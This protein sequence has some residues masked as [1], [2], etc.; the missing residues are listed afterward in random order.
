MERNIA[1]GALINEVSPKVGLGVIIVRN[2][3]VLLG[4]R[5]NS[6]DGSTWSFPGG[7]LGFGESFEQAAKRE[8]LEE[9][10]LEIDELELVSISNDIAYG[11]HYVTLGLMPLIIKGEVE[12]KEPDKF[13]CWEWFSFDKLPNPLFVATK[14]LIDNYLKERFYQKR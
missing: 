5:K 7:H 8:V 12:L 1:S 14:N 6:Y 10:G 4:K 9:T 2:G 11:R 13:E 3:K